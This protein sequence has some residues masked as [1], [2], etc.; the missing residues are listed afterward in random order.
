MAAKE[1]IGMVAVAFFAATAG[2][3]AGARMTLGSSRTTSSASTGSRSA[4]L[5]T[6]GHP[7]LA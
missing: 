4:G 2:L 6:F 3:L 5:F 7:R 1:P